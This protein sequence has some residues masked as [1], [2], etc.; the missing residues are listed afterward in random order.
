MKLRLTNAAN[1]DGNPDG[2]TLQPAAPPRL[3]QEGRPVT[4]RRYLA[5][6]DGRSD[7]DLKLRLGDDYAQAL[8]DGD[9]EIDMEIVGRAIG[10][11]DTVFLSATGEVLYAAPEIVEITYGT[12]GAETDRRT[13]VDQIG[14]VDAPEAPIRWLKKYP[15]TDAIRGFVFGRTIQIRHTSGLE[16]DWLYAM[17]KDLSDE[18]VMVLLGAGPKGRDPLIFQTNGVGWRGFLEGR[19][20]T[21]ENAGKY[22]LLLHLSKQALKRPGTP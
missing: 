15:I 12:D 17:A 2:A 6:G 18:G 5:A 8:I 21:G 14:N 20:G 3:G 1:R 7:S 22:Q 11:T 19:I 16:F 13:P 10:E 9:P 4:F